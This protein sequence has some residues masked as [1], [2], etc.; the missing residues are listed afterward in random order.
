MGKI[1]V[2]V[3]GDTDRRLFEAVVKPLLERS[4][5][6]V[7]ARGYRQQKRSIMNR[8]L[9][10]MS[11]EGFDRMLVADINSAPCATSRKERLKAQFNDLNDREIIVV[12]KEIE[13]WY[14][15]GLTPAGAETLKINCPS[16]TD[17]VTK[18]EFERLRP[19]RFDSQLDFMIELL[20]YFDAATACKRNR[21]F[22]YLHH[23]LSTTRP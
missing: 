21:S 6:L 16:S 5:S 4:Y 8:L 13:S 17:N 9:R 15:A 3:E 19:P 18:Q 11:H 7:L 20:K 23:R 12:S 1:V 22:A 14:L 2:W 10:G